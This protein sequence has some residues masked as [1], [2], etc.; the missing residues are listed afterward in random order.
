MI[1]KNGGHKETA[2][3][4]I[5]D[6]YRMASGQRDCEF[7]QRSIIRLSSIQRRIGV[8]RNDFEFPNLFADSWNSGDLATVEVRMTKTALEGAAGA[9]PTS[10]VMV[11]FKY[12]NENGKTASSPVLILTSLASSVPISPLLDFA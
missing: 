6:F 12:E 2:G 11:L 4:R 7:H 9:V 10:P 5:F 8:S 3:N 1:T